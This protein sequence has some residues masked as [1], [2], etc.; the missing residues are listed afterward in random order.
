[1]TP[2]KISINPRQPYACFSTGECGSACNLGN[3]IGAPGIF[4]RGPG[5]PVDQSRTANLG[6]QGAVMTTTK[7]GNPSFTAAAPSKTDPVANPTWYGDIRY[8]FDGTD[9]AHMGNQGL[10]LTSYDAVVG[11]AGG[12]YGQV[13]GGFMPP[14][15][16][17]PAAW[18]QTFLNWMIANYPKG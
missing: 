4:R 18:T 14:G 15:S 16:P 10:D 2:A 17:W 9:Q 11:S 12:I 8:M 13:S 3:G 1:M 7:T 5:L 6:Q